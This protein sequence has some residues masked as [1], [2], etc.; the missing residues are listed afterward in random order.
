M[1]DSVIAGGEGANAAQLASASGS[2][3]REGYITDLESM[4]VSTSAEINDLRKARVLLRAVMRANPNS[5]SG[6]IAAARVE[7]LDGKLKQ[8]RS[9][10]DEASAR[11]PAAEDVWAEYGR[12]AEPAK[13]P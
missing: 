12:L 2:F 4:R 1:T 9:L 3:N 5:T 10:L 7:E 13:A 11:F 6:W 8:A